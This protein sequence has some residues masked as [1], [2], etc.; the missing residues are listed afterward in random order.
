MMLTER[1]TMTWMVPKGH[2]I[3]LRFSF[4]GQENDNEVKGVGNSLDFGAR[5]YDPRIGRWLST[6]QRF[7]D[8]VPFSPYNFALSNPICFVDA[9]GNVVVDV[10]GNPVTIS[11]TQ[12][13]DGTVSATYEFVKG[14]S[15]AVIDNFNSNGG[16]AINTA[17]Q[18]QTGR[19]AVLKAI[20]SSELI[21]Y[22]ISPDE[23]V[24]TV[25]EK[26]STITKYRSG[27]TGLKP[28]FE[29][30]E[31][32]KAVGIKGTVEDVTIYEGTID[33]LIEDEIPT[34]NQQGLT[35]EQRIGA[36]F[37]HETEHATD[38]EEVKNRKNG[39]PELNESNH[40]NVR[41]VENK[42]VN[43]YKQKNKK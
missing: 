39:Q 14:T 36:T 42:A 40:D 38:P 31:N 12:A 6:D 2:G 16:R 7:K 43:E 18:V 15:Q 13:K 3:S 20:E 1:R 10:N 11:I 22:T 41:A 37:V 21:H 27:E 9:D 35:K 17:I 25:E 34:D 30:D 33:R 4:N 28:L 8:Y 26:E 29:R 19:E 24:T 32:G 5:I 23:H